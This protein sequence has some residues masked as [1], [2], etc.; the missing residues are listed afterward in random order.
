MQLFPIFWIQN[1]TL[2][3]YTRKIDNRYLIS[4]KFK[5]NIKRVQNKLNIWIDITFPQIKKD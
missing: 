3:I 2:S 5:S 4:K 1:T